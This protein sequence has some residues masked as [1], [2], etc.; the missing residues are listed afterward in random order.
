MGRFGP[1]RVTPATRLAFFLAGDLACIAAAVAAAILLRFEGAPPAPSWTVYAANGLV[2]ACIYVPVA[3]GI[4]VYRASWSFVGLR[5]IGR[6]AA[7]VTVAT[8]AVVTMI[9]AARGAGVAT[10]PS[11]GVNLI[12]APIAFCGIA[13]FRLS[14][15]A[16]RLAVRGASTPP[17]AK[18]TLI[19]GAGPAGEQVLTSI[20]EGARDSE[21]W[22]DVV[23]F[24]DDDPLAQGTSIHGVRVLGP[25]RDLERHLAAT[26]A[27]AVMIC[28]PKADRKVVQSI[29]RTTRA[30]GVTK[31][32]IVPSISE[33]VAAKG[34]VRSMRDV[35]VEDLL[36]RDPV[37]IDLHVVRTA[38]AG[39]TA[40]VTGGAGTIGSEL[41]RQLAR[42]GST[43]LVILDTDETRLH[44]LALEFR[45]LFPDTTVVQALLDVRDEVGLRALFHEHDI[46][47][48]FHAAAYK[49]VPMMEAWPLAALEVNVLGT[50]NVLRAAQEHGCEDFVLI[51]T[52]KAVHPSSIMGA[53]KRLAE[54]ALF[55]AERRSMRVKAVRFGNVLGSRG[56]VLPIFETQLKHGGPLTV[57]HPEV[58][59]YFMTTTEAV[60]LVLQSFVL[61]GDRDIFVLDMGK[62]V[63]IVDVAR[64]FVRLHGYDE[65]EIP[66]V[67]TGLR[68][69][70]KLSESL[71]YPDEHLETTAHPRISKTKVAIAFH[72]R[73]VLGTV[74]KIAATHDQDAARAYL[75][76]LFPHLSPVKESVPV[77]QRR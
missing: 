77:W 8:A 17:R 47:I 52:D 16:V 63:R 24:V 1:L 51:S 43:K 26:R 64:E 55:G 69:G 39:R 20:L 62:P 59:R 29:M 37:E 38:V 44:D 40:L 5:D 2:L 70:E 27:E 33:L 36:G 50:L 46:R 13:A 73:D 53:S 7:A 72:D 66:I 15:R 74:R 21:T 4:G 42:F 22:V 56:S 32:S 75:T 54:I 48:V 14:K 9:L 30:H 28:L 65:D 34:A 19:V 76:S 25:L 49:H 6:V 67:F 41:C 3:F 68:P 35:T 60:Q 58:E 23:G 12:T 45:Q 11:L 71:H 18:R 57:T 10:T 61:P 31:V